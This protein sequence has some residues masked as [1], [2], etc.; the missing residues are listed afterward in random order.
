MAFVHPA[1]VVPLA[2]ALARARS[3]HG[4]GPAPVPVARRVDGVAL[5]AGSLG[6]D[7]ADY[8]VRM[9]ARPRWHA[10]P[11]LVVV[12][13]LLGAAALFL[14]SAAAGPGWVRAMPHFLA[15]RFGAALSRRMRDRAPVPV[16]LGLV[17]GVAL[18][19]AWDAVT[20][21]HGLLHDV[22][23]WARAALYTPTT[24][25][26]V[27]ILVVGVLLA[28]GHAR[29]PDAP[30]S[31]RSLVVVVALTVVGAAALAAARY[32]LGGTIPDALAAASAGAIVGAIVSGLISV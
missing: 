22:I 32:T 7:I 21:R 9:S 23:P 6:P 11:A 2:L 13:G 24:V 30:F 29:P 16:L 1:A 28:P 5:V 4:P 31:L 25:V 20:E 15:I 17:V 26:G 27:V 8:F 19:I 12:T 14:A 3:R 10:E 18:H